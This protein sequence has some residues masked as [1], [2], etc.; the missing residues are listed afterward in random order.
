[1]PTSE[2]EMVERDHNFLSNRKSFYTMVRNNLKER[3]DFIVINYS[4]KFA[5]IYLDKNFIPI[6]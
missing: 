1:M 6:Q 3:H 2:L 4:N 5:E